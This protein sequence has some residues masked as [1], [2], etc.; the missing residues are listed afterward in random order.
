[1][2]KF[3]ALLSGGVGTVVLERSFDKGTTWFGVTD[4]AGVL[5][6]HIMASDLQLNAVFEEPESG[7]LYRFDCTWT[8]GVITF[9]LSHN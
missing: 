1:M 2:G 5:V 6:S 7:M 9:R 3:N 4:D 8:S